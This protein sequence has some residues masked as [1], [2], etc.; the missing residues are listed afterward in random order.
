MPNLVQRLHDFRVWNTKQ[1]HYEPPPICREAAL[2][3]QSLSEQIA[4]LR[5]VLTSISNKCPV[6]CE[7]TLAHEMAQEAEE[8]LTSHPHSP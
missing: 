2:E 4:A 5:D 8:A 1:Q 7:M 3:I 6:T